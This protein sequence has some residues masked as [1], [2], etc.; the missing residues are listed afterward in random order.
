MKAIKVLISNNSSIPTDLSRFPE[1]PINNFDWKEKIS[2]T[3]LFLLPWKSLPRKKRLKNKTCLLSDDIISW[4]TRAQ[5]VAPWQ[6]SDR[7]RIERTC[8][9]GS[10]IGTPKTQDLLDEIIKHWNFLFMYLAL[11]VTAICICEIWLLSTRWVWSQ[12]WLQTKQ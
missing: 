6:L 2:K 5:K 8:A 1:K 11:D 12:Y 7:T 9:A 10:T 4:D 3:C